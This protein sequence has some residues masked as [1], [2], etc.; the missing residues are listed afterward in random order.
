MNST[1]KTARVAGFLYLLMI[2]TGVFSL[3]YVPGKLMVRGDAAATAANILA[4]QSLFNIN[5]VNSLVSSILF[6]FVALVLYQLLK[7]VNK[8]LAALMVILVLV[9]VPLGIRDV[10]NQI[11]ALELLR[12]EGF[13]SAFAKT[14]RDAL[15]ML[16]L[17]LNN[18]GIFPIEL[19]WGLWLFPL[20]LLV[21]RSGFLPRFLGIWLIIN[22]LAYVTISF[23]GMLWPQHV[24]MVNKI[25]FPALFGE[26]AF[27]LWLLIMGARV[28]PLTAPATVEPNLSENQ[29]KLRMK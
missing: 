13:W 8:Q 29:S 23:T 27:P 21:F 1:K 12:G 16:F 26:A 3:I 17:D 20:G 10:L 18:K 5:M 19:F 4:S 11:S 24:E 9:Q 15:A 14:Q 25:A 2:P 22:G 6:L 28:Q 7:E